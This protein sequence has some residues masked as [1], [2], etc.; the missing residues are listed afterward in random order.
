MFQPGAS[1]KHT[2][3]SLQAASIEANVKLHENLNEKFDALRKDNEDTKNTVR[4]LQAG[5][6][7]QL[8]AILEKLG[9]M[10]TKKTTSS[11]TSER[12]PAITNP[13][14]L[15]EEESMTV[16]ATHAGK[17]STKEAAML[18]Q[19]INIPYHRGGGGLVPPSYA[20]SSER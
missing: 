6:T 12:I 18:L 13:E 11:R 19:V 17:E 16:Q 5:V 14:P 7:A 9:D 15:Q 2:M 20:T 4:Q 3:A 8:A 10:D 1:G